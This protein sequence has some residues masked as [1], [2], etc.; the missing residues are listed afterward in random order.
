MNGAL[1]HPNTEGYPPPQTPDWEDT[2]G[3][4][5]DLISLSLLMLLTQISKVSTGWLKMVWSLKVNFMLLDI[6]DTNFSQL[7][8]LSEDYEEDTS[9]E[10]DGLNMR[11]I[12]E[13]AIL[14]SNNKK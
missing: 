11:A 9:S 14:K 3:L 7:E 13:E 4:A 2:L 10:D 8:P 1:P 5:K 6:K 12:R